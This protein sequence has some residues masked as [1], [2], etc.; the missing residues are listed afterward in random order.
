MARECHAIGKRSLA[1]TV[2]TAYYCTS[3]C[4]SITESMCPLLNQCTVVYSLANMVMT[5]R[6]LFIG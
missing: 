4:V 5:V 3:V 2:S 6:I 1:M